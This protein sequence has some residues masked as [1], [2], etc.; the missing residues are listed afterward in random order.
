VHRGLKA[1]AA[2]IRDMTYAQ[3]GSGKPPGTEGRSL[4]HSDV[5]KSQEK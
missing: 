4:L 1:L 3:K 5:R 2:R